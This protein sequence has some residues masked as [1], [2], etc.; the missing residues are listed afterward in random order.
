MIFLATNKGPKVF[1]DAKYSLCPSAIAIR[2]DV[3]N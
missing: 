3:V 1:V 2:K